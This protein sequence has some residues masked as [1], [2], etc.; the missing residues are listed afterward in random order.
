[1]ASC[2]CS[3]AGRIDRDFLAK[4]T[5]GFDEL[6]NVVGEYS[7]ERVAGISGVPQ[8]QIETVARMIGEAA[9]LVSTCLQGVYQSNQATAAAVQV[10]N[11][12]LVRGMIGRPGCGVLQMNGQPTAQNTR[13][14]GADGDLPG[15]RN[16]ANQEHVKELARLLERGSLHDPALGTAHPCPAD[17]PL[18][19]D[20]LDPPAL[21]FCN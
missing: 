14:T 3:S 8:A 9:S 6:V 10:N 4:H 15:F 16:W 5:V 1:M 11:I 20:R 17:L 21:D 18:L 13:E 12:N 19:R 2:I 7:P